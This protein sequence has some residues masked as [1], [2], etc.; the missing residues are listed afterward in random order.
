[1]ITNTEKHGFYSYEAKYLDEHGAE[2]KIPAELP[3]GTVKKIQEV[4][5]IAYRALFCEGMARVDSFL[6][7][8]GKIMINE[9]NTLPGFTAISMYPKL[10]EASG[11]SYKDLITELIELAIERG[12]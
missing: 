1:M 6:M 4:S 2:L 3:E 9:I 12:I 11:K 5:M 10:W 8:D 7:E